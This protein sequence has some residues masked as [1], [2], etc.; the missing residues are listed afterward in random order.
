VSQSPQQRPFDLDEDLFDFAAVAAEPDATAE[1]EE[2][3]EE[4]LASFRDVPAEDLL[5]V[6]VA[7][8]PRIEAAPEPEVRAAPV[9]APPPVSIEPALAAAATRAASTVPTPAHAPSRRAAALAFLRSSK[10]VVAIAV[11]VT[12]LNASMAVVLLRGRG[13]H[14]E[15]RAVASHVE[16]QPAPIAEPL[17]ELPSPD[18]TAALHDHPALTTAREELARGEYAAARQRVYAL[19][20][21]IDRLEDPRR[22]ELEGECKFLVAQTLHLEALARLGRTE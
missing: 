13:E 2:D 16:E 7:A 4:L 17:H 11:S 8:G 15:V 18:A 5:D 14:D 21:V 10:G 3:L 20:A 1:V 12:V 19:L 9:P 22:E 6:P